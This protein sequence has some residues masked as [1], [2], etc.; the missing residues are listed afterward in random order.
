[1]KITALLVAVAVAVLAVPGPSET[2]ESDPI[3]ESVSRLAPGHL[4]ATSGVDT[5]DT[6]ALIELVGTGGIWEARLAAFLLGLRGE[7]PAVPETR[8]R[9]RRLDISGRDGLVAAD[10]LKALYLMGDPEVGPLARAMADSA[11][12]GHYGDGAGYT[13]AFDVLLALGDASQ[14]DHVASL[15]EGGCWSCIGD[16][17]R[18]LQVDP[19]RGADAGTLVAAALR[20][21]QLTPSEAARLEVPLAAEVAVPALKSYLQTTGT[22]RERRAAMMLLLQPE[23]GPALRG[24]SAALMFIDLATDFAAT[25]D[26]IRATVRLAAAADDDSARRFVQEAAIGVYGSVAGEEARAAVKWDGISQLLICD[27]REATIYVSSLGAIAGGP[28]SGSPFVGTLRGSDGP[29]VIVGTDGPDRIEGLGGDDTVC[30]LGGD[31]TVAGGDGLDWI[32]GGGG[33]DVCDAE[34]ADCERDA[35]DL[36]ASVIASGV[37]ASFNGSA[38]AVSGAAHALDGTPVAGPGAAALVAPTDDA[39]AAVLAA[40]SDR[41]RDQF[42]GAVEAQPLVFS[43][44]SWAEALAARATVTAGDRPGDLGSAGAPVVAY[45]P[46]GARFSGRDAGWGVLVADG[47]VSF[48]GGARWTGLIVARGGLDVSGSAT[49]V[50]GAVVSG[51]L[52]LG[53]R[54]ELLYSP[55]ALALARQAALTD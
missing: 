49:V 8:G 7:T 26:D 39:L 6:G 43:P 51:P 54:A 23:M 35:F 5:T 16:L 55:A 17:N 22:H 19:S 47:P 41:Q 52:E 40:L 42:A 2:G 1:M 29:D 36:P 31:D 21:G 44:G 50:G 15:V 46:A 45:A 28:D 18:L 48:R 10:F 53:G 13:L 3:R 9:L 34:T 24:P 14:F 33:D 37:S 38:F 30:A 25:P 27:G 11:A 32:D 4:L 12:A 20:D